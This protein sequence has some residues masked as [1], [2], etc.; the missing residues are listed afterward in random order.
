MN[1]R[2][3]SPSADERPVLSL[4]Y[5]KH[6]L[7]AGRHRI[8]TPDGELRDLEA[9]DAFRITIEPPA[10]ATEAPAFVVSLA[11]RHTRPPACTLSCP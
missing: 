2:I 11:T 1:I 8:K 5:G 7:P 4:D 9:D 3:L 6:D 10:P